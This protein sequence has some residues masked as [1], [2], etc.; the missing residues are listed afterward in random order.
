MSLG[1]YR[2]SPFYSPSVHIGGSLQIR[3]TLLNFV[4]FCVKDRVRRP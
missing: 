1:L 3:G 4:L 2:L